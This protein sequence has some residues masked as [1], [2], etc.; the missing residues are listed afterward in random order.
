MLFPFLWFSKAEEKANVTNK[1]KFINILTVKQAVG[2]ADILI[3]NTALSLSLANSDMPTFVVADDTDILLLLCWYS[4][5]C[6]VNIYS[7]PEAKKNRKKL[8]RCWDIEAMKACIDSH[9]RENNLVIQA[10]LGCDT[11][12]AIYG[13]GKK[14]LCS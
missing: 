9:V 5:D 6:S 2:D 13:T 10:L 4:Q 12:S 14:W 1:Q 11:T 7:H 3:T 8:I